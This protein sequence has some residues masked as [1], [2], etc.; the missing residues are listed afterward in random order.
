MRLGLL[1]WFFATAFIAGSANQFA[2]ALTVPLTA[3]NVSS[4]QGQTNGLKIIVIEGEDAVNVVQQKT[5]VAPLVEVRD[6]NGLP[7]AGV[8]VT[9][10]ISAGGGT[11]AGG[12]NT[13]TV[14]TTAAGRA[15]AVGLTPTANGA[16]TISAAAQF[17]GQTAVATIAQ[18][19]VMTAAQA[20]AASPGATG[21]PAAAGAGGGGG[22]SATTLAVVGGAVA[23]GAVAAKALASRG[24]GGDI[25]QYTGPFSGP[26]AWTIGICSVTVMHIGTVRMDIKT[27]SDGTVTGTGQVSQTRTVTQTNCQQFPVG[28][29]E[30]DGCCNPSP[31]VHG[32]TANL[33]FTGSHPG[34]AGTNWTYDFVG[35][36]NGAGITG[37][38][39]L[40]VIQPG[41]STIRA[42][43]PVT[44]Q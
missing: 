15:T 27:S 39:T 36:L 24:G 22:F 2:A 35:A 8:P 20:A 21:G 18:T 16:L 7:V 33:G 19:N 31:D 6:R 17:Q 4:A 25:T 13:L 5:A 10:S 37:T 40:T 12:A 38:F 28:S 3:Q 26:V 42:A 30:M 32:T 29:S 9:F 44:L 41:T 1:P 11:F 23:G 43:F 34:N 14:V